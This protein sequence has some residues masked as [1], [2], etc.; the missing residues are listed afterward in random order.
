MAATKADWTAEW[1]V[2]MTVTQTVVG[3]VGEMVGM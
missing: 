1:K 2:A 3:W